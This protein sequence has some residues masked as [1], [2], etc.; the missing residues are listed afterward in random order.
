MLGVIREQE[1]GDALEGGL[2]RADL[3][4][5]INAVAVLFDHLGDAS[6]LTLDPAQPALHARFVDRVSGHLTSIP[7]GGNIWRSK[8]GP[9]R[10][11]PAK[12]KSLS[13]SSSS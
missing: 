2:D 10:C 1:Q 12:R 11:R 7:Q 8:S 6:D 13:V 9:A 3:C 5:D 4:Q